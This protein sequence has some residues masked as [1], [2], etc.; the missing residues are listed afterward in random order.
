MSADRESAAPKPARRVPMSRQWRLIFTALAGVLLC[1]VFIAGSNLSRLSQA[2]EIYTHSYRVTAI[3]HRLEDDLA[4]WKQGARRKLDARSQQKAFA[5]RLD[6]LA[7]LTRGSAVQQRQVQRLRTAFGVWR[8]NNSNR[9]ALA[10]MQT[11]L[12]QIRAEEARLS[13]EQ[14]AKQNRVQQMAGGALLLACICILALS[15]LIFDVVM[16]NT[17]RLVASNARLETEITDHA[18]AQQDL[19]ESQ[20]CLSALIESTSDAIW[21][22]DRNYCLTQFNKAFCNGVAEKFGVPCVVGQDLTALFDETHDDWKTL[23]DRALSGES[24]LIER[25]RESRGRTSEQELAFSPIIGEHG[26]TGATVFSRD[27]TERKKID[28]LKSEFISTVSHELRTPLTSI[29]GSLG[30]LSGEVAGKLPPAAKPLIDIAS[31]NAERL[32]RLINDILDIEKIE[33]GRVDFYL[34]PLDLAAVVA[35][36]IEG[37][38][39]YGVIFDVRYSL[40]NNLPPGA[41]VC[42]DADRLTQVMD[43]LISNAVKFSPRGGT[44]EIGL[45]V[46]ANTW[47]VS[48]TDQGPG[49]PTAF[50]ERIFDKFAQADAS[51]TRA[52]GGTGLGLSICKSI[53]EKLG[54][55][56]NYRCDAKGT[57]FFFDLPQWGE[58]TL[59]VRSA[60]SSLARIL[61]CED[62]P[63]IAEL[64]R[65]LL[66]DIGFAS[67][68]ARNIKMAREFLDSTSYFALT[69][70]LSLPDG[71]GVS[72]IR[73]L[74]SEAAT[75]DL[76]IVVVSATAM[77]G[78]RR[79]ENDMFLTGDAVGIVD[80]LEKPIDSSRLHRAVRRAARHLG[81]RAHVLHIEDDPDILRVVQGILHDTADCDSAQTMAQAREKLAHEHY[82]LVILDVGLPDG[83]GLDLLPQLKGTAVPVPVVVFSARDLSRDDAR[84]TEA[85]LEKSRTTN[86]TLRATIQALLGNAVEDG[87]VES[88]KQATTLV[89]STVDSEHTA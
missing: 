39:G 54:G 75:R 73:D 85:V 13:K 5:T 15:F 28:R 55:T 76:P 41:R 83:N 34:Q 4:R 33:T 31:S 25:V 46:Q 48:V 53:V 82:D 56:I 69:L 86:T 64:L 16:Q 24:F 88:G 51:D 52:K 6:N 29:R 79:L 2:E 63:D 7:S 61:I 84:E 9:T 45:A 87:T 68:I 35:T 74:R 22:V 72:F 65:L 71:D 23:Y 1:L 38:K 47:R 44:V 27:I 11:L 50:Q 89:S 36:A 14:T 80:W 8:A 32:V 59:P 40:R 78:R 37:A 20:A 58:R 21:S 26:V 12:T 49:V 66:R 10:Q 43:N 62:D 17:T 3:V 57:T 42:A 77:Q 30:L 67:D 18:A 60:T 81:E 19:H 70:D